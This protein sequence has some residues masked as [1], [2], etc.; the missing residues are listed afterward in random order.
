[1]SQAYVAAQLGL[2]RHMI[3][4][5]ETRRRKVT[6]LQLERLAHLYS[7]STSEFFAPTFDLCSPF[8]GIRR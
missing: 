4:R 6:S 5:I 3:R 2:P 1:M 8:I 7:R